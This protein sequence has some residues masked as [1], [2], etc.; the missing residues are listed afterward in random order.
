MI[1]KHVW[2]GLNRSCKPWRV[3]F[4]RQSDLAARVKMKSITRRPAMGSMKTA[5]TPGGTNAGT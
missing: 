3:G 5:A 1:K 4:V 2:I